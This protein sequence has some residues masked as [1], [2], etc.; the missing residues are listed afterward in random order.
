MADLDVIANDIGWLKRS[1]EVNA[2]ANCADHKAILTKLDNYSERIT[3]V[4]G[5][6]KDSR[7]L[8]LWIGGGLASAVTF[9][10][11]F[12]LKKVGISN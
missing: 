3:K 10:I 12:I 2:L 9:A 6:S 4:E 7:S 1:I 11:W 8:I 5:Q